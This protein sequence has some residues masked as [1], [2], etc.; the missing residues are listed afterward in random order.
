MVLQKY[1]I[2]TFNKWIESM[3][4]DLYLAGIYC[5]YVLYSY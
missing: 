5:I 1:P 2:P 4:F 3:D